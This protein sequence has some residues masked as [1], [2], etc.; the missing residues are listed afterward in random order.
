MSG[1]SH[2]ST[3][4][5]KKGATDVKRGKIFS[6]MSRLIS[7]AAREKGSDP[8]MN[9]RLRMAIDAARKENMPKENI[10]RAIKKGSGEIEGARMEEITYEA[11]G[12][13]GVAII[14]EIITDNKNRTI[15]EIRHALKQHDGKLAEGGSVLYLFNKKENEWEPKYPLEITDQKTVSQLEKLFEALEENDDVQEIYSNLK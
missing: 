11:Y 7:I 5:H 13:S 3:I 6:K 4:K 2:F 12:P 15:A 14:I 9:P 1:H 8:E 10:E